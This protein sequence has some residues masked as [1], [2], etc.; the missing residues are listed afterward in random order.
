MKDMDIQEFLSTE[1][2]VSTPNE[3]GV[4]CR[5]C[6]T[7]VTIVDTPKLKMS[8]IVARSEQGYLFS[9]DSF[10]NTKGQYMASAGWPSI[11]TEP[12]P[13]KEYIYTYCAELM[14]IRTAF[15]NAIRRAVDAARH[16][17]LT[18]F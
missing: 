17:R 5:D 18:L 12:H 11:Y 14:G 8:V 13:D 10:D 2:P 1:I 15:E 9:Y 4:Y 3:H 6:Q 16:R 7:W